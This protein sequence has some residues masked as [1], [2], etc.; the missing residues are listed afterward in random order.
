MTPKQAASLPLA[1]AARH[2]PLKDGDPRLGWF[3]GDLFRIA[4]TGGEVALLDAADAPLVRGHRWMLTIRRTGRYATRW[5]RI[6]GKRAQW[7]MHRALLTPADGMVVDHINGD[8]LDNRRANLRVATAAENARNQRR[9]TASGVIGVRFSKGKYVVRIC[10]AGDQR[11]IG[12][13]AT[14]AEAAQARREAELKYHGEFASH[15]GAGHER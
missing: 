12:S 4:L 11:H 3:D 2:P 15:I 10:R 1:R 9:I 13:F 14:L 5:R 7:A 8:G 6:D